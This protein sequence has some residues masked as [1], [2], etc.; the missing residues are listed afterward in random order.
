V[1]ALK[2]TD[3]QKYKGGAVAAEH[4]GQTAYKAA[5]VQ[6]VVFKFCNASFFV[7]HCVPPFY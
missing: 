5:K 4:N 6:N 2:Q 7:R 3:G 1:S